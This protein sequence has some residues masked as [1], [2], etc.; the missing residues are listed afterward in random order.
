MRFEISEDEVYMGGLGL[1]G[2]HKEPPKMHNQ[3]VLFLFYADAMKMIN[4]MPTLA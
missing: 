4:I 1:Q 2:L 3:Y